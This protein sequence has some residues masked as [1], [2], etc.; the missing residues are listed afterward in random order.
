[1]PL[2]A[3]QDRFDPK[4]YYGPI[5]LAKEE[6]DI[7]FVDVYQMHKV[8]PET[9]RRAREQLDDGDIAIGVGVVGM[10]GK[11]LREAHNL[12][13][14]EGIELISNQFTLN[15][16]DQGAL[17]DGTLK[18]CQ[19]LG[20]TPIGADPPPSLAAPFPSHPTRPPP[21]PSPRP[22]KPATPTSTLAARLRLCLR[23]VHV[24]G[25]AR[26]WRG[27]PWR[28][29]CKCEAI[30]QTQ[31]AGAPNFAR[32]IGERACTCLVAWLRLRSLT[33]PPTSNMYRS[34]RRPRLG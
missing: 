12:L 1:M 10:N 34:P 7:G 15:L 25:P 17:Y 18:A 9:A 32:G 20:V 27:G 22:H 4:Q 3:V 6:L 2:Y 33:H 8:T 13:E 19:E 23:Q 11:Q 14:K 26:E 29:G 5:P 30:R 16:G 31:A 21:L 28:A 24:G